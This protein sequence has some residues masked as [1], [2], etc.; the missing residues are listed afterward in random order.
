MLAGINN[1]LY[2][3]QLVPMF[4]FFLGWTIGGGLLLH[5]GVKK[6]GSI[7]R[8]KVA[9]SVGAMV[10]AGFGAAVGAA[11]V[12]LFLN[13]IGDVTQTNL[14]IA[15]GVVGGL[16][17]MGLAFLVV[18]TVLGL[19][20]KATVKVALSAM[21]LVIVLGLVLGATAA[22][23]AYFLTQEKLN[24]NECKKNVAWIAVALQGREFPENLDVL[25][26]NRDLA[27]SAI[28]C[29]AAE[30]DAG[31]FYRP[32]S[33]DTLIEANTLVLCDFEGSHD[34]RRSIIF[35][36]TDVGAD[37][38]P[39][40]RIALQ[41]RLDRQNVSESEFQDLLK[42]PQNEEFAKALAKAQQAK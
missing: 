35:V 39:V 30:N 9:K 38:K 37:G 17:A 14:R 5:R 20:A 3:W 23:P 1:Y 27:A 11:A 28:Q 4:L 21:V 10:L 42:L 8:P 16:V 26:K 19:S 34:G 40:L 12:L 7:R 33:G 13:K 15:S 2:S 25:V 18:Y 24:D 32:L 29:P 31:Y 36:R 22:V 6:E 41:S